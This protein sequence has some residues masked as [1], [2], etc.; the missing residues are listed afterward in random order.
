L[1]CDFGNSIPNLVPHMADLFCGETLEY[2][3]PYGN[4]GL[5]AQGEEEVLGL[6]RDRVLS[7]LRG[8]LP[9][10]HCSK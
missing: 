10:K 2:L 9:E 4:L 7:R 6:V 3:L 8:L 1:S 5:D